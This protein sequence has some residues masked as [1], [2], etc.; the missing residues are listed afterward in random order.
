MPTETTIR[1]NHV[2]QEAVIIH[3]LGQ[4]CTQWFFWSS[5]VLT[6]N[7][8]ELKISENTQEL[9]TITWNINSWK[10]FIFFENNLIRGVFAFSVIKRGYAYPWN[11]KIEFE[12]YYVHN[13]SLF[14]NRMC[15]S[16]LGITYV[17]IEYPNSGKCTDHAYCIRNTDRAFCVRNDDRT[18]GM[19]NDN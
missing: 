11:K 2:K 19:R 18:Y 4:L 7:F 6:K 8:G 15:F 3:L 14:L 17:V 9:R 13:H 16:S 5:N 12:F 1:N 10:R